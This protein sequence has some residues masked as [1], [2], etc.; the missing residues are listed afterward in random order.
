MKEPLSPIFKRHRLG[1]KGVG[2]F[3]LENLSRKTIITTY[4]KDTEEGFQVVFDWDAYSSNNDVTDVQNT[5]FR[6]KAVFIFDANLSKTGDK[7]YKFTVPSKK[8]SNTKK[9]KQDNSCCGPIQFDF[10]SITN[11]NPNLLTLE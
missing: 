5:C 7:T 8:L 10:I 1:Q 6:E 4:P 2:R 11:R 3:A 9:D